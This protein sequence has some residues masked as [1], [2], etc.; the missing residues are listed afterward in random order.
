MY[1]RFYDISSTCGV[2]FVRQRAREGRELFQNQLSVCKCLFFVNFHAC[3]KKGAF[4]N[5]EKDICKDVEYPMLW[6]CIF[7]FSLKSGENMYG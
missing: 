5:C 7:I 4:V 2:I 1:D 6:I 3:G